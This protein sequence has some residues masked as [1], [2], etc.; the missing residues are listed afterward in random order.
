MLCDTV[1][2]MSESGTYLHDATYCS[3]WCPDKKDCCGFLHQP[4]LELHSTRGKY[5]EISVEKQGRNKISLKYN[6]TYLSV[7]NDGTAVF[8]ALTPQDDSILYVERISDDKIALK[9]IYNRYL[10]A[11][12]SGC[13]NHPTFT[14]PTRASSE[15]WTVKCMTKNGK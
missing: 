9:S 11:K 1:S 13:S 2:L 7:S 8:N 10:T 12:K 5:P 3:K 4:S 14:S 15:A 6:N